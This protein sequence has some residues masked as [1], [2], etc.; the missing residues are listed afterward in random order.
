[1]YIFRLFESVGVS[2]E[3]AFS[4]WVSLIK[5][6]ITFSKKKGNAHVVPGFV[7]PTNKWKGNSNKFVK[8]ES[9]Q[10]QTPEVFLKKKDVRKIHRKT[11]VPESLF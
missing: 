11:P 8:H 5:K 7:F 6:L 4:L 9:V 2:R 3:G 1:M 10:K